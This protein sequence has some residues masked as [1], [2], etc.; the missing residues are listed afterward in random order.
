MYSCDNYIEQLLIAICT[1]TIMRL[2]KEL[3]FCSGRTDLRICL[4]N[5]HTYVR[6]FQR[7]REWRVKHGGSQSLMCEEPGHAQCVPMSRRNWNGDQRDQALLG[8]IFNLW[9]RR[10]FQVAQMVKS[11]PAVQE[12]PV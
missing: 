3:F 12:T 5:K 11:L 4:L 6:C 1:D 7:R 8:S 2:S 9:M 10:A